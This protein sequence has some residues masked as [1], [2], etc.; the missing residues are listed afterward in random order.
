MLAL[1]RLWRA[2]TARWQFPVGGAASKLKEITIG[3]DE[4]GAERVAPTATRHS[5]GTS[6]DCL[7]SSPRNR[8]TLEEIRARPRPEKS[9]IHG[10]DLSG[11]AAGSE[12]HGQAHEPRVQRLARPARKRDPGP[13]CHERQC[14]PTT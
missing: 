6:S 4:P 13:R 12:G 2:S 7:I 10:S 8:L 5:R 11:E 3:L 1:T 14:S 9:M